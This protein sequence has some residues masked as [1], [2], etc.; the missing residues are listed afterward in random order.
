MKKKNQKRVKKERGGER[1]LLVNGEMTRITNGKGE[2][3]SI[4]EKSERM[5]LTI[6]DTFAIYLFHCYLVPC[7]S[8]GFACTFDDS[9]IDDSLIDD[10]LIDDSLIDDS[11]VVGV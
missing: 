6:K 7:V 11:V 4:W 2:R 10:S 8:R 3:E 1:C 9:L 5:Q